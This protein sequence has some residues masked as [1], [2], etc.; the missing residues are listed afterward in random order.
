MFIKP[1]LSHSAV[2]FADA[3]AK[4]LAQDI[5]EL[6]QILSGPE[7]LEQGRIDKEGFKV[8]TTPRGLAGASSYWIIKEDGSA[9]HGAMPVVLNP[10]FYVD[11]ELPP[12]SLNPQLVVTAKQK[13]QDAFNASLLESAIK[14]LKEATSEGQPFRE[15]SDGMFYIKSK[16]AYDDYRKDIGENVHKGDIIVQRSDVIGR[17]WWWI[18]PDGSFKLCQKFDGKTLEVP[19]ELP[20]GSIPKELLDF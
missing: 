9:Q 5:A 7:L 14:Q 16:A 6:T 1:V 12:G 8:S 2:R 20:A 10:R 4:N 18:K 11:R 13:V 17:Y 3:K 15:A 19:G